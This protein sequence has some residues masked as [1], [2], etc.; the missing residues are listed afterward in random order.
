MDVFLKE[1]LFADLFERDV[2]TY[3]QRE[4][5]TISVIASL[6]NLD[7]MLRGHMNISLN[8]GLTAA[9]LEEFVKLIEVTADQEKADDAYNVL[10]A[11]LAA[12]E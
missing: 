6:G 11:V 8:V 7:P 2:L 12:R 9:Q 3:A 5:T 4:L 10:E 1:H